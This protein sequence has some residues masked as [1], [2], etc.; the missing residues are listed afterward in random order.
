MGLMMAQSRRIVHQGARWRR[1]AA[2][3]MNGDQGPMR[4]RA[5]RAAVSANLGV[6]GGSNSN[7]EDAKGRRGAQRKKSSTEPQAA[8]K[9]VFIHHEGTKN[10]KEQGSRRTEK[11]SSFLVS[12]VSSWCNP[13]RS[14]ASSAFRFLTWTSSTGGRVGTM[15]GNATVSSPVCPNGPNRGPAPP[16]RGQ[17]A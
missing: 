3:P 9:K 2:Q 17:A 14:S 15:T 8:R 12:F 5:G 16:G 10:T 7:A 1:I 11:R 4:L 6:L 13:L